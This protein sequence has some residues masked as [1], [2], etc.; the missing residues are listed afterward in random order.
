MSTDILLKVVAIVVGTF[1]VWLGGHVL[2]FLFSAAQAKWGRGYNVSGQWLAD[3]VKLGATVHETAKLRQV[4]H[5]VWGTIENRSVC[6]SVA[7]G[8]APTQTEV[9]QYAIRGTLSAN[10][11]VATYELKQRGHKIDSGAFTLM[12]HTEGEM[13]G[14]YA[15]LDATTGAPETGVYVWKRALTHASWRA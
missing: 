14:C 6:D 1:L 11:L 3:Y 15:W 2:D 7:A 13:R 12:L 10:V 8:D 9:R 5:R 4:F